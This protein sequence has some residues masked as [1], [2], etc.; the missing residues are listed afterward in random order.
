MSDFKA[1]HGLRSTTHDGWLSCEE[2]TESS[3]NTENSPVIPSQDVSSVHS[4]IFRHS[5]SNRNTVYNA[6]SSL[7]NQYKHNISVVNIN[8]LWNLAAWFTTDRVFFPLRSLGRRSC[9]PDWLSFSCSFLAR[10]KLWGL[11][12]TEKRRR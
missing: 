3:F 11:W 5:Q 4:C 7:I 12:E 2:L 1:L 8:N 9:V 6:S 10:S